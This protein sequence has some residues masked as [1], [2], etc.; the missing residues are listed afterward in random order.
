LK[1]NIPSLFTKTFTE[2][3]AVRYLCD[4]QGLNFVCEPELAAELAKLV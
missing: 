4:G 3:K 2:L 1:K